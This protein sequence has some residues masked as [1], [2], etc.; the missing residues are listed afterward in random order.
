MASSVLAMKPLNHDYLMEFVCYNHWNQ[1]P[2]SADA[3]FTQ[4]EKDSMFFTRPWFENLTDTALKDGES[5]LLACVIN[6]GDVL[7]ILPV[8]KSDDHHWQALKHLYSSLYTLLIAENNQQEILECLVQGL[9][10]SPLQSLRLEPIAEDDANMQSLQR[11]MISAG[12]YADRYY[13]FYNW[14]HRVQEPSFEAYMSARPAKVRNTIARKQRKLE[15]EH[16]YEIRL[17]MGDD[18]EPAMADYN[19]V[20]KASWKANELFADILEGT[21]IHE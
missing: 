8:L 3:L 21:A 14:F 13:R 15:R 2:D 7:A 11:V 5:I 10:Q 1:L 4:T 6:A 17:F 20:Y 16:G 18:V 12:F 19:T 9:N